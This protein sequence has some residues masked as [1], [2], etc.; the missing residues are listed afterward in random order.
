MEIFECASVC[1]GAQL[2]IRSLMGNIVDQER[3]GSD[4]DIYSR[5]SCFRDLRRQMKVRT[6]VGW[7]IKIKE[8]PLHLQ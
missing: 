3:S 8:I 4:F 6:C 5:S 1:F 7:Y 2:S